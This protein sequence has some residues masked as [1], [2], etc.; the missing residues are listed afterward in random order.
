METLMDN[1]VL[2]RL[3]DQSGRRYYMNDRL[4]AELGVVFCFNQKEWRFGTLV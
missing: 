3:N 4:T 2:V 1:R